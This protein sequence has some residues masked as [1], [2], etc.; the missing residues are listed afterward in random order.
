VELRIADDAVFSQR[1]AVRA[2]FRLS[3]RVSTCAFEGRD[4]REDLAQVLP[5]EGSGLEMRLA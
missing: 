2:G 1:V 3:G 5:A 4:E